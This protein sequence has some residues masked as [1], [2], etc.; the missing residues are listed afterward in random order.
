M[1][2]SVFSGDHPPPDPSQDLTAPTPPRQS[3]GR[4]AQARRLL[5]AGKCRRARQESPLSCSFFSRF[6]GARIGTE[7]LA[8]DPRA[9][10]VWPR[11]ANMAPV[12]H[13]VADAGAFLLDAALQVTGCFCGEERGLGW[14]PLT[15][16]GKSGST[17]RGA[18]WCELGW[19]PRRTSGRTSTPSGM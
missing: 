9:C 5:R 2:N 6:P 1:P 13:V 11:W 16:F 10:A 14:W 19:S 17:L 12:E 8:E 15:E 4:T 18:E 3:G 7:R